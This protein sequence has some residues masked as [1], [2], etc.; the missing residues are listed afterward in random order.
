MDAILIEE[1]ENHLSH[2]NLRK[3]VQRVADAQNGQLF[4]T[5]HNSLISTRLELQNLNYYG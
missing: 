1:P 5:T 2:V 4:I 3:L